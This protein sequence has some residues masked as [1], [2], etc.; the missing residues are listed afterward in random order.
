MALKTEEH[1]QFKI[2]GL[3][4]QLVDESVHINASLK[5]FLLELLN[6]TESNLPEK[7]CLECYKSAIECRR[8][9]EACQKSISKLE[10]KKVSDAMILGKSQTP[11]KT[12]PQPSKKKKILESLGLDPEQTEID[13]K[14]GRQSR[15]A[16]STT[17]TPTPAPAKKT[18][19]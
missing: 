12:E 3:C 6:V 9:K 18:K 7:T 15:S 8:F 16:P 4:S 19:R 1:E 2:C 5:A 14:G 10:Q 11:V 17:A 13:V